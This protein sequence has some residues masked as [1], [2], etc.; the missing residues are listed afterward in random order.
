M[1]QD[2]ISLIGTQT[3]SERP[4]VDLYSFDP[5]AH[6][7]KVQGWHSENFLSI[8]AALEQAKKQL[9][10]IIVKSDSAEGELTFTRLYSM[11]MGIWIEARLHVLLYENNAFTEEERA[12]IYNSGTIEKKWSTALAVAV[13]K[14]A[15]LSFSEEITRTN[16][17]FSTYNIY[18]EI[19]GWIEKYFSSSIKSR[20]KIAHGQW[21]NPFTSKAPGE[22]WDN[23]NY[24]KIN[25]DTKRSFLLVNENL[26]TISEKAKLLL[27]ISAAINNLSVEREDYKV[28]DF[29]QHYKEISEHI[30]KLNN[31][32]YIDYKNRA[33]QAYLARL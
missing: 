27:A 14:S 29:D 24:F 11:L 21:V 19:A 1:T 6:I 25:T 30:E 28:K 8:R 10:D 32:N 22:S 26:L 20:N 12:F 3:T 16:V 18:L 31:I 17:G 13:K 5:A 4:D 9:T 15:G 2:G 33:R 7:L 23:S